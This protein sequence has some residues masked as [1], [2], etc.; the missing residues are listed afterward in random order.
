MIISIDYDDTWTADPEGWAQVVKLLRD[1]GHTVIGVT[2]RFDLP[3]YTEAPK[4]DM[5]PHVSAIVFAGPLPKRQAAKHYGY[6][7]DIW[8]DDYPSAVDSGRF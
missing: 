1:R 2:N 4:R 7:V 8:I 5:L 6:D 3:R